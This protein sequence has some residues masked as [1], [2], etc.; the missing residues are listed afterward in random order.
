MRARGLHAKTSGADAAHQR[1]ARKIPDRLACLPSPM[2]TRVIRR[3][4]A[5]VGRRYAPRLKAGQHGGN[6]RGATARRKPKLGNVCS[7]RSSGT[8]SGFGTR[9]T[10]IAHAN[11]RAFRQ[12]H[13]GADDAALGNVLG[14][15]GETVLGD[16]RQ[17]REVGT[18]PRRRRIG[19][20][21]PVGERLAI[22]AAQVDG[23][24]QP[25]RGPRIERREQP[26]GAAED[27]DRELPAIGAGIGVAA[28]DR[29]ADRCRTPSRRPWSS[30]LRPRHPAAQIASTTA[31]GRPP[32][33]AT[34]DTLTMT[35]HQPANHGSPATNSFM[36][37]SM[38]SSRYPSPSG[39]AA[40]SSPTGM[41]ASA[42]SERRAATAAI[43]RLAASPRLVA[44]RGG[45]FA[46]GDGAEHQAA[47]FGS[48]RNPVSAS[49][50]GG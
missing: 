50:I 1:L 45:K 10:S 22:A 47:F 13:R 7:Q 2:T 9:V 48:D 31:I 42:E 35:P 23:R 20:S 24:D 4:L 30:G 8:P 49:A 16:R 34:S 33:A 44:Q 32:M 15:D 3:E 39:I 14:R 5:D 17:Q 21:F 46:K 19:R 11:A 28:D 37:P 6:I 25:V 12:H 43:S 18:Q 27:R 26:F 41:A 29:H 38:A 36:K 40:Q